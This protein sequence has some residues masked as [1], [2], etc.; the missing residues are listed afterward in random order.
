MLDLKRRDS[1]TVKKKNKTEA[2][3]CSGLDKPTVMSISGS[4]GEIRI[5]T[6]Y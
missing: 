6:I 4:V 2:N 5:W 1:R 3:V